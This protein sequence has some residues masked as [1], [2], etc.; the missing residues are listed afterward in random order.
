MIDFGA[1]ND[2]LAQRDPPLGRCDPCWAITHG[3]AWDR[4]RMVFNREASTQP[5]QNETPAQIPPEAIKKNNSPRFRGKTRLAP[6]GWD[7]TVLVR[8]PSVPRG[9]DSA[10]ANPVNPVIRDGFSDEV[11]EQ[12]ECLCE[13]NAAIFLV[14]STSM[15]R[16]MGGHLRS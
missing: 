9:D 2:P 12:V 8:N 4:N 1:L 5:G 15:S 10:K 14:G 11:V 3:G 7:F 6:E 13:T 16:G